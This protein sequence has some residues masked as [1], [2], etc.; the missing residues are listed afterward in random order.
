MGT[1]ENWSVDAALLL[2]FEG[3]GETSAGAKL[4]V[5]KKF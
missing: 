4:G 3:D 1:V 2:N 5:S